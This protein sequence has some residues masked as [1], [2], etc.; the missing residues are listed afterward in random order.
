MGSVTY[1]DG[2]LVANW[3]Y[4]VKMS[5]RDA[6]FGSGPNRHDV[7][8]IATP[9]VSLALLGLLVVG[10]VLFGNFLV[11]PADGC[12]PLGTSTEND[13]PALIVVSDDDGALKLCDVPQETVEYVPPQREHSAI[14]VGDST[15]LLRLTLG[16]W[17]HDQMSGVIEGSDLTKDE[18][19]YPPEGNFSLDSNFRRTPLYVKGEYGSLEDF[20]FFDD[21]SASN[22]ESDDFDGFDGPDMFHPDRVQSC[23]IEIDYY[24]SNGG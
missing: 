22:Y 20:G 10:A 17:T 14:R 15:Y 11:A 2:N 3:V 4:V 21:F 13:G 18:G 6:M 16:D 19:W 8:S 23:W 9:V 1:A 5:E 12:R 7:K 24:S